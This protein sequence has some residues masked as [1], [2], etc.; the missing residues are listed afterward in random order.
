MDYDAALLSLLCASQRNMLNMLNSDF[1]QFDA[2]QH[3]N[4]LG[5]ASAAPQQ[6]LVN[7]SI[8]DGRFST[9]MLHSKHFSLD[10]GRSDHFPSSTFEMKGVGN[11]G[12]EMRGAFSRSPRKYEQSETANSNNMFMKKKRR[13]SS[14]GFLTSTFFEDHAKGSRRDSIAT[15][16][17][18]ASTTRPEKKES[19]DYS[20]MS[21]VD[22]DDDGGGDDDDD[23]MALMRFGPILECEHPGLV[24]SE[25]KE[26]M[27]AF[28]ESMVQSQMSQQSIHDWDKKMGLKRS[29]SK[30]MRL[31]MRSRK[32]LKAMVKKGINAI[33]V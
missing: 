22:G 33:A 2:H 30:T 17:S 7:T 24:A 10:L 21:D 13:L 9:D 20:V 32:K 29:H 23:N 8:S 19:E 12:A 14:L 31:S 27:E 4:L 11:K 6:Q 15:Y 1:S 16:A 26:V 18:G 5:Q 28:A 25:I 3:R